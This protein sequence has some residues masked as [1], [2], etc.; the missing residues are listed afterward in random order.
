MTEPISR[1]V[2]KTEH[3]VVALMIAHARVID[4]MGEAH[5]KAMSCRNRKNLDQRYSAAN[6][7]LT[8]NEMCRSSV[9]MLANSAGCPASGG[10]GLLGTDQSQGEPPFDRQKL[11]RQ[12]QPTLFFRE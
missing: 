1:S 3:C 9:G 6:D 4:V 12:P 5:N 7:Q 10:I 2:K 11:P 8:E